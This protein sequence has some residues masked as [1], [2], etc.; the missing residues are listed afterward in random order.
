LRLRAFPFTLLVLRLAAGAMGMAVIG[1]AAQSAESAVSYRAL[2]YHDVQEDVRVNPDPYAVDS[3]QLVAQ[4]AWMKDNGYRVVSLDDVI[5]A[6]EGRRALPAKAVVLTFDD[7]YRSVYTRVFPL[8]KLF[9]YP[10]IV[11]LSGLWLDAAPGETVEYEGKPLP[12]ERFLSWEQISEMADSGLVE[13]AS[14]SYDLHRGIPANPQGSL[15]PAVIAYRYDAAN[16]SYEDEPAHMARLR[17][18]LA[19][20][21]TLIESKVGRRP[22]VMV[23]PFGRDSMQAIEVARELGMPVTMSLVSG[24]NNLKDDLSRVRRAELVRNPPLRDFISMVSKDPDPLPERVV[25]VDLDYVYDADP[26]QQ[27]ANIDSLLDRILALRVTTVYLQAFADGDGNGQAEAMYFPNRHLPLR[28]DLFSYVAWQLSTR[29][30]VKVYAW[31]PVLAFELPSTNSAAALTVQ[32]ADADA[33]SAH[34]RYRRLSPFSADAQRVIGEIYEDLA[35]HA[36]FDGLLFHDD[37]V[38]DDFE[39]A[40]PPALQTYREWGLPASVEAIRSDPQLLQRWTELKTRALIDF[41]GELAERV[42]DYQGAIKTARNLY[43][44]PVLEPASQ[45]WF[46]QSLPDFLA[47]YDFTAVMAMPLMEGAAKPGAWLDALVRKVSE[48]PG[49]LKKTVFELQSMDWNTRERVPT[50]TLAEQMNRLQRLGAVNFG[51]YP[52]DFLADQP[53]LAGIKPAISLQSFPR[54]D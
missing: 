51:Y 3:A 46:A 25:H 39:D 9:N 24:A 48:H 32:S 31:M 41:T 18:D 38:L 12:R 19:R 29:A 21:S 6:R 37:A 5:A 35:R 49:A 42:R 20:N 45:A 53:G 43:A 1:T 52:D 17:A 44:R 54:S 14:H 28:A 16:G 13:M 4:F 40:S 50:R 47:A 26:R 8:L 11:A 2:C 36:P 15:V 23:W 30:F 34:P 27:Q 22:R 10:A 33:A 7:G